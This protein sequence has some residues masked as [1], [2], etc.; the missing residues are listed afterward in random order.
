MQLKLQSRIASWVALLCLA[1][2]AVLHA[3][4]ATLNDASSPTPTVLAVPDSSNAWTAALENARAAYQAAWN[5]RQ[6]GQFDVAVSICDRALA[7]LGQML[8]LNPDMAVR[9]ELT[10][11]QSRITGLREAAD[12]DLESANS[13]KASGNEPDEKT[14]NAPAKDE[15]EP[16]WNDQVEHWVEFFTGAGRSTFERWLKRSGR[17]MGLFRS[18]LQREGLPPD[19]VH[20]VFVE[21]GFNVNARSVSAAVG[22]W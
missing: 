5:S 13:A 17:Y 2:P 1:A 6:A 20:L 10:D 16:Q 19:L 3:E 12:K 15:I 11:L 22:P 9:R 21:S 4:D 7:R 18:V 14:L 8:A